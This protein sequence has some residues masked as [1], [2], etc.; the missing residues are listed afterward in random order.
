ML[1]TVEAR[2]QAAVKLGVRLTETISNIDGGATRHFDRK[3]KCAS[4][5][6]VPD[7]LFTRK[8]YKLLQYKQHFRQ[9][10]RVSE[11]S[12]QQRHGAMK[13]PWGSTYGELHKTTSTVGEPSAMANT[14]RRIQEC[15]RHLTRTIV[16][17]SD[18]GK[19]AVRITY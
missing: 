19:L 16:R 13:L 1:I 18:M 6:R 4:F 15:V 11:P 2:A 17:L 7:L 12:A 9:E 8:M 10:V 5:S 3:T 14:H